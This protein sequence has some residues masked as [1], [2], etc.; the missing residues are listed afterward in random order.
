[1]F[2]YQNFK[3]VGFQEKEKNIFIP[4]FNNEER[5]TIT[6]PAGL[7]QKNYVTNFEFYLN[8]KNNLE[9]TGNSILIIE[10]TIE[11]KRLSSYIKS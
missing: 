7:I 9:N 11:E 8:E 2:F 4:L 1:M 3:F 6:L 5:T 10:K